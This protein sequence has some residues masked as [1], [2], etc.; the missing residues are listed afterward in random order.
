[1]KEDLERVFHYNLIAMMTLP[2]GWKV[3]YR[4]SLSG[5][6]YYRKKVISTPKPNTIK[7]L[8][9]FLHECGHAI[10][11][12]KCN[13][14]R[15]IHEYEAEMFAFKII[16]E[17]G[18]SIPQDSIDNSKRHINRAINKALKRGLKNV[19][20]NILKYSKQRSNI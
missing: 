3:K 4:N 2:K 14:S 15:Y 10:L 8:H 20:E 12:P 18:F 16:K 1:M 17:E 13:K 6:C 19:D 7:S 5:R 9:V 11:H